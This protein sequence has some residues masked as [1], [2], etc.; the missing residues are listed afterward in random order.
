[1]FKVAIEDVIEEKSEELAREWEDYYLPSL[2]AE[3]EAD[4][5]VDESARRES[6]ANFIDM[7]ERDGD[8]SEFL[9]FHCDWD[10]ENL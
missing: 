10:I 8:L 1:M 9:A 5:E 7:K 3:M 4:G 2:R 6:W